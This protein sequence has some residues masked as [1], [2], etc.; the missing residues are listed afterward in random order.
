MAP[1]VGM[2][3]KCLKTASRTT[4]LIRCISSYILSDMSRLFPRATMHN[5]FSVLTKTENI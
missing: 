5:E 3:P 2:M 1:F 4:D